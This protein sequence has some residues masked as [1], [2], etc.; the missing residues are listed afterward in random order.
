MKALNMKRAK[1]KTH[2][3]EMQMKMKMMLSSEQLQLQWFLKPK[4]TL[5]L[6]NQDE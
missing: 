6:V 5:Q 2:R 3:D 1:P 4:N